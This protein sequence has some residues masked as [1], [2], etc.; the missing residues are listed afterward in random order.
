MSAL[1]LRAGE[2]SPLT[3]GGY[4]DTTGPVLEAHVTALWID[5]IGAH[6]P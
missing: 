1:E 5:W 2:S 4:I 3:I 6:Q